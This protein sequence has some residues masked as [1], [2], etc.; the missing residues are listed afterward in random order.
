MYVTMYCGK[1]K[2]YFLD[3]EHDA[4]MKVNYVNCKFKEVQVLL[5]SQLTYCYLYLQSMC[6]LDNHITIIPNY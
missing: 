1:Y 6:T 5:N 4:M 2:T 3:P